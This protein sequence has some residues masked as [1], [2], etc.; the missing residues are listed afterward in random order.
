MT[1]ERIGYAKFRMYR[2]IEKGIMTLESIFVGGA[3][4]LSYWLL[5]GTKWMAVLMGTLL[6]LIEVFRKRHSFKK[7]W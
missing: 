5:F 4:G 2:R 3:L 7:E 6:F 1:K